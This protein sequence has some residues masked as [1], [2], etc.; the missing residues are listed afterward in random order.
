MSKVMRPLSP[1]LPT[2]NVVWHQRCANIQSN[3]AT[4]TIITTKQ[5]YQRC[6]NTH[7]DS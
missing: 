5:P 3:E 4:I 1:S 2:N 7:Y 6:T